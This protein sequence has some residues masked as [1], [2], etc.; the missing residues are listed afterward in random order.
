[1]D[2]KIIVEEFEG[3]LKKAKLNALSKVSLERQLTDVEFKEMKQLA[4]EFL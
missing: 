1:M 4:N 3:M 2:K